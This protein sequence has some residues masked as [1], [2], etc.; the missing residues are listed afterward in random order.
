MNNS[1]KKQSSSKYSGDIF[2]RLS[3]TDTYATNDMKTKPTHAKQ[4]EEPP[5]KP[6]GI[7]TVSK[8]LIDFGVM[9]IIHL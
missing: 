6:A 3:K 9:N 1:K 8:I 4:K 2:D 7:T 5:K